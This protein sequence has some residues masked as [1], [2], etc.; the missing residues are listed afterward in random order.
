MPVAP[1][2][3]T[4]ATAET[5]KQRLAAAGQRWLGAAI[6]RVWRYLE[7]EITVERPTS[8]APSDN[9]QRAMNLIMPLRW[10]SVVA[11]AE[12]AEGLAS[13]T[14]EILAG[15]N[16]VGTVHF[17]RFDLIG[18]NLCMFSIYDGN[19]SGYLRDFIAALG[20]AF[21]MIMG[22]VKHPPTTPVQENVDE[23]I[24][25]ITAHDAFQ[26][27]EVVTEL[28]PDLSSLPR[29]LLVLLDREDNVQLGLYRNYPGFTASQIRE[30]LEIGW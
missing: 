21:D 10:T 22:F 12:L 7:P 18:H 2:S 20:P 26:M 19:M 17:A 13:A 11:R 1:S 4:P 8:P 27:P 16:N 30:A 6:T 28:A 14:A 24:A 3:A 5:R 25:W 29:R 9:M 23:F 15:L